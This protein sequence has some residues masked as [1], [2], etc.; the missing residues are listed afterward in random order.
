[1]VSF[2]FRIFSPDYLNHEQYQQQ[3]SGGKHSP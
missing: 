2:L 3:R 1:M